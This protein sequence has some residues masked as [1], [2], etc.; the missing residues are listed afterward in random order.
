MFSGKEALTVERIW[1]GR[2]FTG[3]VRFWRIWY[4]DALTRRILGDGV[5][6]YRTSDGD[7]RL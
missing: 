1:I 5:K 3:G 6:S 7:S 2:C 4:K